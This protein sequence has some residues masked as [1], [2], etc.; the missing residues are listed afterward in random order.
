VKG[1]LKMLT[2]SNPFELL[3]SDHHGQYIPQVFAETVRR[4]LFG[5]TISAEDWAVLESGPDHEHYCE[6]WDSVL[7][8]AE[9]A[10][11]VSLYQD[12]DLWAVDWSLIGDRDDLD[13]IGEM[14]LVKLRESESTRELIA[15]LYAGLMDGPS[16]GRWSQELLTELRERVELVA[17][18]IAD[19][20]PR[21]FQSDF[22]VAE[23]LD[24]DIEALMI[25]ESPALT[26]ISRYW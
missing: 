20:L 26:A 5:E 14:A 21:Y 6:T 17:D 22:C 1:K 18:Q 15:E 4:D 9:T 8:S 3:V 23:E 24:V 16:A 7:S 12:G 25:A 13:E 19:Q 11:G 2:K 10:D